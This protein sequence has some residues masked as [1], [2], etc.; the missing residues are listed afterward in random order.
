MLFLPI[1]AAAMVV[2]SKTWNLW[3]SLCFCFQNQSIQFLAIPSLNP[4]ILGHQTHVSDNKK[5]SKNPS[6]RWASRFN[7][8]FPKIFQFRSFTIKCKFH[9]QIQVSLSNQPLTMFRI[10]GKN[11]WK[12]KLQVW[13]HKTSSNH[14][15]LS[16]FKLGLS[17]SKIREILGKFSLT[18]ILGVVRHGGKSLVAGNVSENK[19]EQGLRRFLVIRVC[20][21][22]GKRETKKWVCVCVCG[23]GWEEF[24]FFFQVWGTFWPYY[25]FILHLLL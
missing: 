16:Y 14:Q 9:P 1:V 11:V 3:L 18:L 15:N 4:N 7:P 21:S 25:H 2:Y 6:T 22:R 23:S 17:F 20:E 5:P 19:K 10:N 12:K 13:K 24:L 8:F